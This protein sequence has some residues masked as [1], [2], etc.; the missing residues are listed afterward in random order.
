[1]LGLVI[2][3]AG[4]GPLLVSLFTLG[5][6]RTP[7]GRSATAMTM[8]NTSI[9]V[10]QAVAGAVIGVVAGSLGTSTALLGPLLATCITF[11]VGLANFALGER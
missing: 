6:A 1:M 2:M 11:A 7:M 4:V 9:L 3:G 8:I 5:A 10:G